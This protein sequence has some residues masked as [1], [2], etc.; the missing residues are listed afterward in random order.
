MK[1]ELV[2]RILDR[3]HEL[4]SS[5]RIEGAAVFNKQDERLGVIHSVMLNKRSGRAAYVVM[6]LDDAE[7]H[8]HPLP[9]AMLHY[10]ESRKGY[11]V[12][13][14]REVLSHAPTFS[15]D[16]QDRPVVVPEAAMRDFYEPRMASGADA[17]TL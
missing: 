13:L 15:L 10:D 9:W 3:S 1:R 7:H 11:V 8:A 14:S 5:A 2:L 4:T 6:L 16:D 17:H 12:D